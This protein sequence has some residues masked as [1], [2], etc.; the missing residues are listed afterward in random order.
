MSAS[1]LLRNRKAEVTETDRRGTGVQC[2]AELKR[3]SEQGIFLAA[4][5]VGNRFR[6]LDREKYPCGVRFV[7]R[8]A[9]N[10]EIRKANE[11]CGRNDRRANPCCERRGY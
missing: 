2:R 6:G 7:G 9:T 1:Q 11:S 4:D 5:G 3:Y 10:Q 8:H